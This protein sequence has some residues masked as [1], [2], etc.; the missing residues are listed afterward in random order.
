MNTPSE[1][2]LI[3]IWKAACESKKYEKQNITQSSFVK[4]PFEYHEIIISD[5]HILRLYHNIESGKAPHL[6][7]MNM[8]QHLTIQQYKDLKKLFINCFYNGIGKVEDFLK[9]EFKDVLKN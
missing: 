9:E 7:I 2:S 4:E 5:I 8:K 3:K 1:I 6:E